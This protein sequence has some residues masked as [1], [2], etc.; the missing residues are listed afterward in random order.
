LAKHV[1]KARMDLNPGQET[2]QAS[3]QTNIM[4]NEMEF[5]PPTPGLDSHGGSAGCQTPV[6]V[7]LLRQV[8]PLKSEEPEAILTLF[9]RLD[10]IFDLG[11]VNDRVFI[12][13][14]LPLVAGSLLQFMGDCLRAGNSWAECKSQ[15]LDE[16][17][18]YF[19]RERLVRDL[20][21]LNFHGEGQFLRDYIE[22]V[23]RVADSLKYGATKQQ[24][25]DRVVMNLHPT[26]LIQ[27][28]F[29]DEPKTRRDLDRM[30]GLMEEKSAVARERE[31]ACYTRAYREREPGGV[32]YRFD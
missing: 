13:R 8:A 17:F 14:I 24:L 30:V 11:I 29:L 26:V 12:M 6:V 3:V 4:N 21:V 2:P 23:F 18:P 25:V 22:R 10:E 16:Y 1:K 20:I 31:R 7:K 28:A 27:A 5:V 19:V 15:L 32:P 9:I